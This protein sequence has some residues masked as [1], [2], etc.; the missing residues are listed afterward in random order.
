MRMFRPSYALIYYLATVLL[1]GVV[2][3]PMVFLTPSVG[4]FESAPIADALGLFA[5]G[6]GMFSATVQQ[7]VEASF[8]SIRAR[9]DGSEQNT[10]ELEGGP[11]LKLGACFAAFY[12]I[13]IAISLR[14]FIRY[15][16]V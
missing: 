4:L 12:L 10:E 6:I 14:N 8:A 2:S 5:T 3:F 7:R 16:W 13:S 15:E 1:G 9:M 11:W